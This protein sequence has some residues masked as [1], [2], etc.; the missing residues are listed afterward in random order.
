MSE[1]SAYILATNPACG[2][3]DNAFRAAEDGNIETTIYVD[4]VSA[5]NVT[6]KKKGNVAKHSQSRLQNP[7]DAGVKLSAEWLNNRHRR[8]RNTAGDAPERWQR[9]RAHPYDE[10]FVCWADKRVRN[11][12]QLYCRSCV[13]TCASSCKSARV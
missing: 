4:L 3:D 1:N 6:R 10:G 2:A 5:E 9:S 13:F 7:V 12:G 11:R 8:A